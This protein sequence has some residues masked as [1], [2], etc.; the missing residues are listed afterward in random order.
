MYVTTHFEKNM[1][2]LYPKIC[3]SQAAKKLLGQNKTPK[4]G[5]SPDVF[6]PFTAMAF[7]NPGPS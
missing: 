3:R 6:Q 2:I 7:H 1:A 4:P 5:W